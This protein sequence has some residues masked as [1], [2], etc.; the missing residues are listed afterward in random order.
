MKEMVINLKQG[1]ASIRMN[2]LRSFLAILGVVIG[3]AAVITVVSFGEGH[4][5]RIQIEIDKIGADVFWIQPKRTSVSIE[6]NASER[7]FT[8]YQPLKYS[9][10]ECLKYYGT[11]INKIAAFHN[12]FTSLSLNSK[13][14][15]LNVI[16]TEPSYQQIMKLEL[17]RGRFLSESDICESRKVCVIEYSDYLKKYL[18]QRDP[19]LSSVL[20]SNIKFKV[21]GLLNKKSEGLQP[22]YR[23]NVYI[24]ITALK[25]FF[26]GDAIET[27]YCQTERSQVKQALKQ[28]EEILKSRYKGE[29]IFK[30][31]NVEKLFQ[32]A[33]KM[34]RTASLV[35]AGIA[36]ISLIVGGIGI[37]NI[38]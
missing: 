24:P 27:I 34:T 16:A 15:N 33:E 14:L 13:P 38:M 17:V 29:D 3:V 26:Y 21:I 23:G 2:L 18:S 5:Q 19:L 28:A 30:A 4:R 1:I 25:Y 7:R 22:S 32:S 20:F 11:K 6:E 12:L 31:V 37:M 35:T 10:I 36:M 9:D 8:S